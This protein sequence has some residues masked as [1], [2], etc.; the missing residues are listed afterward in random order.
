M[1]RPIIIKVLPGVLFDVDGVLLRGG[2]VIP[3]AQRALGKL[4]DRNNRFRFPVVF[5]TNAGSC[6]RQHKAQQLSHL[7]GLQVEGAGFPRDAAA[8]AAV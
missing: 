8:A 1:N 2:S 4:V 5:V 3:A 7:L 6:L